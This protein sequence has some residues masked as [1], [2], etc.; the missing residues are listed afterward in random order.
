MQRRQ[1]V[2]GVTLIE[3]MIAVVIVGILAAIAYPSFADSIRK[4]RRSEATTAL[5]QVQQA[6]ER[7]RSNAP[8]YAQA[9]TDLGLPATTP[10]GRY[11][12]SLVQAAADGGGTMQAWSSGYI[13]MAHGVD[14]T[15][16]ANDAQCRRL[17][18]RVLG[19]N[20]A[21]A[22]CGTCTSFG[23]SDFSVSHACWTQ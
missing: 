17:A 11:T 16:Q 5:L 4:S 7:L 14:G 22:G 10:S 6:Q 2:R 3:L 1:R 21:Y 12:I 18:V 19:G 15:S 9:V 23:F 13:A 20:L 8:A